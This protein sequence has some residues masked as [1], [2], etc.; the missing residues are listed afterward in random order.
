MMG[1]TWIYHTPNGAELTIAEALSEFPTQADAEAWM[2]ESWSMLLA[3][4]AESVS[5]LEDERVVYGPMG[6]SAG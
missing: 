2:G 4:G 6:L 3:S 1:F 5:L